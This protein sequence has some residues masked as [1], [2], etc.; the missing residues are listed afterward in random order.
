MSLDISP[1]INHRNYRLLYTGQFISVIGTM[2]TYVAIPYQIHQL[3]QS[4]FLVGLLGAVQLIP[5]LLFSLIGGLLADSINRQ[6]L[7]WLAELIMAMGVIGL[8]LNTLQSVP[9]LTLIFTL[10]FVIQ[11]ASA[12]HRPTIDA[13]RQSLVNKDEYAALGAL[14]AFQG[15]FSMI[16]GPALAGVMIVNWGILSV[17]C[18]DVFSFLVAILCILRMANLPA[19][20]E[21]RSIDFKF[22]AE[23]LHYAL[24]RP[25]L[26][27][28][29]IVDIVAMLF[30]FP[31]ALFPLMSDRWGGASAAGL[32]YAAM[33]IGSLL[34]TLVSSRFKV[35]QRHGAAVVIAAIIWGLG[36]I[37]L[38]WAPSLE[39]A[40]FCLI[41]AGAA[42][43]VSGLFR[44]IIWNETIPNSMRGRLAGVEMISYLSGPLL[45][46]LR[47]G[48]MAE[49]WSLGF[50][51]WSGGVACVIGVGICGI[52]LPEFWRYRSEVKPPLPSSR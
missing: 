44:S 18:L 27:G 9:N 14:G 30:A 2:T 43:M 24:K 20:E 49:Q 42:D 23:G 45:G 35:I 8:V 34:I 47:A 52:L 11:A 15:S 6:R 3:T 26:V 40:L 4:P 50:S 19:S 33:P 37:G 48:F 36:I 5:V 46:N 31:L 28:T 12:I 29:Y 1:L 7:L 17:Y 16:V 25:E 38:G 10:A 39:V 41:V 21:G 32:L 51:I 13:M 22:L